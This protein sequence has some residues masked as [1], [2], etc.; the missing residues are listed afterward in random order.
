MT[1]KC[2][3][4]LL[5]IFIHF[6]SLDAQKQS[7]TTCSAQKSLV[8][9]LSLNTDSVFTKG[10]DTAVRDLTY[11]GND[12]LLRNSASLSSSAACKQ[13]ASFS[14]LTSYVL[15]PASSDLMPRQE[16][17]LE[18][19]FNGAAPASPSETIV[20]LF[21]G[22]ILIQAN[23]NGRLSVLVGGTTNLLAN[24]VQTYFTSTSAGT[25]RNF[26]LTK[27][28]T[29]YTISIDRTDTTTS[30]LTYNYQNAPITIGN[31]HTLNNNFNGE[32][33]EFK[34]WA[35]SNPVDS[36]TGCPDCS[37]V[38]YCGTTSGICAATQDCICNF[39]YSGRMCETTNSETC[40]GDNLKA[41]Y[42]FNSSSVITQ[43][44]K[45][46]L[47]ESFQLI[48]IN[49]NNTSSNVTFA[50]NLCGDA[51]N[52]NGIDYVQIPFNGNLLPNNY[53]ALEFWFKIPN[54]IN[55][56]QTLFYMF[57]TPNIQIIAHSNSQISV[58]LTISGVTTDLALPLIGP[59]YHDGVWHK[60]TIEKSQTLVETDIDGVST[61][62]F[63]SSWPTFALGQ[64]TGVI[65]AKDNL[66]AGSQ[67]FTGLI[68]ELKVWSCSNLTNFETQSQACPVCSSSC[69]SFGR[70]VA[71]DTCVC[72][73]GYFGTTCQSF[74]CA[75][76]LPNDPLV[77]S[78][79]GLC[80]GPNQCQCNQGY[81]A[82][83]C[84]MRS[85]TSCPSGY[86]NPPSCA[87]RFDNFVF[88]NSLGY[89]TTTTTIT[90][91]P[92]GCSSIFPTGTNTTALS[93]S[94]C[95]LSGNVLTVV[96]SP[97][98]IVVPGNT[99]QV[100]ILGS[101]GT[102]VVPIGILPA[103][104]PQPPTVLISGP[105]LIG[106]CDD[107]T[108]TAVPINPD[109]RAVSYSWTVSSSTVSVTNI[110]TFLNTQTS[111]IVTIS[112]SILQTATYTFNVT[113][114]NFLSHSGSSSFTTTRS[115]DPA[116]LLQVAPII[117][118]VTLQTSLTISATISY[119]SCY[120][121]TNRA[122]V[123]LWSQISGP[124]VT[125]PVVNLPSLYIPAGNFP[126]AG[127]SYT[128]RITITPSL[129][130]N[131]IV[132]QD[133]NVYVSTL[134]VV[135]GISGLGT[136]IAS[137]SSILLNSTSYDPDKST[138][139]EQFAWSCSINGSPCTGI[140]FLNQSSQNL[141][142]NNQGNY[143]ISLIYSKGN[144]SSTFSGWVNVIYSTFV[145]PT[146]TIQ[147][148]SNIVVD[149]TN[150]VSLTGSA[151]RYSGEVY[152]FVW[153]QT[154]GPPIDLTNQNLVITLSTSR[155]LTFAPFALQPGSI[156]I[157]RLTAQLQTN[158]A[159]SSSTYVTVTGDIPPIPGI[160][161]PSPT[162]GTEL[163]TSFSI[164]CNNFGD[165]TQSLE[166]QIVTVDS[167]GNLLSILKNWN[168]VPSLSQSI[169]SRTSDGIVR[170]R[171]YAR[172]FIGSQ[173]YS[174]SN[175][176]ITPGVTTNNPQAAYNF[177]SNIASSLLL[178]AQQSGS[179]IAV[180]STAQAILNS[181]NTQSTTVQTTPCLND[182]SGNGNCTLVSGTTGVYACRCLI[183]FASEDCSLTT[184]LFNSYQQLISSIATAA[185]DAMLT[186]TGVP[187]STS[188]ITQNAQ[189]LTTIVSNPSQ[190]NSAAQTQVLNAIGT[191][192]SEASLLPLP[193]NTA[194][195]LLST[196][197]SLFS[198]QLTNTNTTADIIQDIFEINDIQQTQTTILSIT[199][200]II[201]GI[202]NYKVVGE[203]DSVLQ[204][205]SFKIIVGKRDTV[206][207]KSS[208]SN[209]GNGFDT[210]TIP[211]TFIPSSYSGSDIR[212]AIQ[213]FAFNPVGTNQNLT[214]NAFE[215]TT[216]DINNNPIS[217][218]N[219]TYPFTFTITA[220]SLNW[221]STINNNRTTPGLTPVCQ[222]YNPNSMNWSTN[223]CITLGY[224]YS[225][226]LSTNA[227]F[228]YTCQCTHTTLF[229]GFLNWIVPPTPIIPTYLDYTTLVTT[230]I[231][232]GLYFVGF[233][234]FIIYD[235][236]EGRKEKEEPIIGGTMRW[237]FE[238]IKKTHLWLSLFFNMNNKSFTRPQRWTVIFMTTMAIFAGS[239]VI[240]GQQKYIGTNPSVHFVVGAFIS[241]LFAFPFTIFF[242]LIFSFT[243]PREIQAPKFSA[244][245]ATPTQIT[246]E[247][248]AK[249]DLEFQEK[250]LE[251]K[252]EEKGEDDA[253][254]KDQEPE[255]VK[256][257][258]TSIIIDESDGV[259]AGIT[260]SF[261]DWGDQIFIKIKQEDNCGGFTQKLRLLG[262]FLGYTFFYILIIVFYSL[263]LSLVLQI[264]G[265]AL[266]IYIC[267]S[268]LF[269]FAAC[270]YQFINLRVH[271][272]ISGWIGNWFE[273]PTENLV[274]TLQAG[275]ALCLGLTFAIIG[276]VLIIVGATVPVYELI[277]IGVTFIFAT[278]MMII[279]II[280]IFVNPATIF[281]VKPK[282]DK[283][284]N[285]EF[286]F[287]FPWWTQF[288]TYAII[289]IICIIIIIL[290]IAFGLNYN[291]TL[292]Q[293]QYWLGSALIGFL[294]E[295]FLSKPVII[296]M[297][298]FG[299]GSLRSLINLIFF[300]IE[301]EEEKPK[302]K[303][304]P[305]DRIT[306]K[307]QEKNVKSLPPT[308]AIKQVVNETFETEFGNE[309]LGIIA[310]GIELEEKN[311][312][313]LEIEETAPKEE[314]KKEVKKEEVV[315]I[316]D[317]KVGTVE[318]EEEEEEKPEKVHAND[319]EESEEEKEIVNETKNEEQK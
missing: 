72:Q 312:M 234:F 135:A 304:K 123:I 240:Y 62:A 134:P 314:I 48:D 293:P 101:I 97:S 24:N 108:L 295:I 221:T 209:I 216:Y 310:E 114:T 34:V 112:S 263:L 119:S 81:T 172:D 169:F 303:K 165:G 98:S 63:I 248:F 250:E 77:C 166:Y 58:N 199:T 28:S 163:T 189:F 67:V 247:D 33:D 64:S 132:T 22:D 121:T 257:Q 277:V 245:K 260:R 153:T 193:P 146:V 117:Q 73:P 20:D 133:I 11:N 298:L 80:L 82:Q 218:N 186:N 202:N 274:P 266:T 195:S 283:N 141:T 168:G 237:I 271:K 242:S 201:K 3:I 6:L 38:N 10:T 105:P 106:S 43:P 162:S 30:Q 23:Q 254:E 289:Y 154:S 93:P 51:L 126:V 318:E 164:S 7:Y 52:P 18:F 213:S 214:S 177:V 286:V 196:T 49:A 122:R 68:D 294:F 55:N 61:P 179:T 290:L 109:R 102:Q 194:L 204:T 265:Y 1:M 116:I 230:L 152:N 60:L 212:L 252:K 94:S 46:I 299:L 200:N 86:F 158:F 89:L 66:P 284:T 183:G 285:S 17:S 219:L 264:P 145:L 57:D 238:E 228:Y 178:T 14:Q 191:I 41:Y 170:I 70:C 211:S 111:A 280:T 149:T 176:T 208:S 26:K 45:S 59:N 2:L 229:G 53:Y 103:V 267:A 261:L 306:P 251:D 127:Q 182:C 85:V 241:M 279:W 95:T 9:Y 113:A 42:P 227:T 244:M 311:E 249:E 44:V 174:Q 15:I 138:E 319:S 78:G 278:L 243:A 160:T 107:L 65:I 281:C 232:T 155:V 258:V 185:I 12:G 92:N 175:I 309:E 40:T 137:G 291:Y 128:F 273:M 173:S 262:L 129:Y 180:L 184:A 307:D 74:A 4:L 235:F 37:L 56:P 282:N 39:G 110:Q 315:T 157:F 142:F 269:Y 215:F 151:S 69:G 313:K 317:N 124:T 29:T 226:N 233:I 36:P 197:S 159:V 156:Y 99:V 161:L 236:I 210:V 140:T 187:P 190:L 8:T 50:S 255:P 220:S 79:N 203:S 19:W 21:N 239:G 84:S 256:K 91:L 143:T 90:S 268:V 148:G 198:S 16:W 246:N 31:N 47:D 139:T 206:I 300:E 301:K 272:F 83:D 287:W 171:C 288:I 217:I 35:C 27:S 253:T 167:S 259:L 130:P 144:R 276:I 297:D 205:S 71:K 224:S 222:W 87:Q 270:L 25:W 104:S 120:P 192:T 275:L 118:T 292:N 54:P 96:L 150:R 302:I 32:V 131:D 188:L 296:I 207:A 305:I 316:V 181:L 5:T 308:N 225:G 125:L 13:S 100:N 231:T 136:T 223:G 76:R 147:E 88:S 115:S 75:G